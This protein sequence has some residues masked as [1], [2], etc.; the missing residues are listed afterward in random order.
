M[1]AMAVCHR[2]G[3]SVGLV[4]GCL[5]PARGLRSQERFCGVEGRA[6]WWVPREG[7]GLPSMCLPPGHLC[8]DGCWWPVAMCPSRCCLHPP[9][10]PDPCWLP[11]MA[12]FLPG[13]DMVGGPG[14]VSYG[15]PATQSPGGRWAEGLSPN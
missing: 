14:V 7:S 15:P 6:W 9:P 3:L 2:P 10:L 8:P 13:Q 5:W 1:S 12:L 11:S 4:Q